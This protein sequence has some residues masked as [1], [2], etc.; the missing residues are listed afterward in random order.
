MSRE[1]RNLY[2]LK[3]VFGYFKTLMKYSQ[4]HRVIKNMQTTDYSSVVS[5]E[6]AINGTIK[7]LWIN[8]KLTKVLAKVSV[9]I[10]H[11]VAEM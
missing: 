2:P 10:T 1:E 5:S 8:E 9:E 3:P 11:E 4:R 7:S 6:F